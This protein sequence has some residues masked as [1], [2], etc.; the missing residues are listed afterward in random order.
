MSGGPKFSLFRPWVRPSPL[1]KI[2]GDSLGWLPLTDGEANEERNANLKLACFF[3]VVAL[4]FVLAD[5]L[6]RVEDRTDANLGPDSTALV[7][8]TLSP[9]ERPGGRVG[10]SVQFRLSNRGN[11]SIFYPMRTGTIAPLGQI[12][13]RSSPSSEWISP[14]ISSRS[15]FLTT[16]AAK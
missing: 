14:S 11:H 9:R 1:K 5:H 4:L 13:M 12:V 7:S 16:R 2:N 15:S 10:L 6:S 8:L 3:A